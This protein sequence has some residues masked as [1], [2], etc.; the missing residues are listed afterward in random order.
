MT[1]APAYFGRNGWNV[2]MT[3]GSECWL[4]QGNE[5]TFLARFKYASPAASAKHFVKFVTAR[6]TPAQWFAKSWEQ[7]QAA[8]KAAGYVHYNVLK[9]FKRHGM[10]EQL[11]S[12]GY[13]EAQLSAA[14]RG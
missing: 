7:Q 5:R 6:W 13:S 3:T 12:A 9:L 2:S 8:L 14:M 11:R 1:N 10:T 4:Y